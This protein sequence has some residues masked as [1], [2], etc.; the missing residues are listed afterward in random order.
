MNTNDEAR[1]INGNGDGT[2]KNRLRIGVDVFLPKQVAVK[3]H[4][5][6]RTVERWITKDR[7][8]LPALRVT[9]AQLYEMGY[10]GNLPASSDIYYL[11]RAA[12]ISLIPQVRCYPK[13]SKRPNRGR[14]GTATG[15]G[16]PE[17]R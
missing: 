8:P 7:N 12:D 9:A 10:R 3:A 15:A 5:S 1:S 16:H 14:K 2:S 6:A 11:V 13:N 17:R 4:V